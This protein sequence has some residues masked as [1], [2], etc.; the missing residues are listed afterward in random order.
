MMRADGKLEWL[1]GGGKEK[2]RAGIQ[3]SLHE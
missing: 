2:S 3:R 1:V